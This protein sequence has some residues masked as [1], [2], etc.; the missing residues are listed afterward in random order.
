MNEHSL[1]NLFTS[2]NTQISTYLI[3]GPN[4]LSLPTNNSLESTKSGCNQDKPTRNYFEDQSLI[5]ALEDYHSKTIIDIA[6]IRGIHSIFYTL[7]YCD[8]IA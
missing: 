4:K 1:A 2:E 7:D 5:N 6:G 3:A 8:P